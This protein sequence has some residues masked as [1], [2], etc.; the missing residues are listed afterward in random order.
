[1]NVARISGREA[2]AHWAA[3]VRARMVPGRPTQGTG[4]AGEQS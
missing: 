2:R 3:P 4:L 1:M